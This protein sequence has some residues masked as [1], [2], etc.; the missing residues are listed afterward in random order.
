MSGAVLSRSDYVAHHLHYLTVGEG[1]WTFHVDSLLFAWITGLSFLILFRMA[2]VR[3]TSGV[4]GKLQNLVEIVLEFVDKQVKESFH[5]NARL[6]T[7]VAITLFVWIFL[8]NALDLIPVDL[9]PMI[10]DKLGYHNLRVVPTADPNM[11]LG[12]SISVFFLIIFYNLKSKGLLG[13][14][15][16]MFT[17][18]F[19]PWLFPANVIL[20]IVDEL[21]K[22]I[23]LGLRLFGN[24]FAGELIFILVA[25]MPWFT[26]WIAGFPWAIFHILVITLQAYIFMMLTIVYLSMA[27]EAH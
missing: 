5:G 9:F 26:Q 10:A 14:L 23:S 4:P 21:A 17:A 22:P 18:P 15:K 27:N 20:R 12:M 24:M 19:G 1:F 8:M 3:A 13:F 7:P 2:A 11:T 25:T 16:E 6:I